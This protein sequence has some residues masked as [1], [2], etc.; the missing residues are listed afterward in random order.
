MS[1]EN[2]TLEQLIAERKR[3]DAAIRSATTARR[4]TLAKEHLAELAKAGLGDASPVV[5]RGILRA[6]KAALGRDPA[7]TGDGQ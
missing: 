1:K 2:M 3:L 5:L 4:R 7:P 6:G